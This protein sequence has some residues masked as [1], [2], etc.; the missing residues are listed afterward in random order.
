M[1]GIKKSANFGKNGI[2]PPLLCN[3]TAWTIKS[4]SR[5]FFQFYRQYSQDF[6]RQTNIMSKNIR[7]FFA[8]RS[9]ASVS[10][11]RSDSEGSD[12][13]PPAQKK[14]CQGFTSQASSSQ[15]SVSSVSTKRRHYPKR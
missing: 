12:I 5:R 9:S 8:P 4:L 3:I 13:E 10:G 6:A 1:T 15:G 14:Q 11:N 2:V 7:S